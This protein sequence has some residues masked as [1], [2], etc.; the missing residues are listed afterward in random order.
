MKT[1]IYLT[2]LLAI[3]LQ[4]SN[5]FGQ[6]DEEKLYKGIRFGYQT[7]NLSESSSDDLS[8]FYAGIFGGHAIGHGTF[9]SIYTGL[10]YYQTGTHH[11]NDNEIVLSYLSL[12]INL[13]GRIGPVY[14]FLGINPSLKIGEKVK[15]LGADVSDLTE[16]SAFDM[17][18]QFGL[19]AKIAFIGIEVKYNLG[20]IDIFDGNTTSHLQA[21]LCV[22]F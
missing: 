17:G 9:F 2:M 14:A 8:S 19:G 7:S 13:R 16:I 3:C 1:N 12:P 21:G 10:E 6:D 22:Y 5:L 18:S 4:S 20:F 15:V 11:D